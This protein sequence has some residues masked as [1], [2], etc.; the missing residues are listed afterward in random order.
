MNEVIQ[1]LKRQIQAVEVLLAELNEDLSTELK[2]PECNIFEDLDFASAKIEDVLHDR[3]AQDC[4]GSYNC[5]LD[6][7]EQYFMV[8]DKTYKGILEVEYN[9]HDKTYYYID[10]TNFKVEEVV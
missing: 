9:R 8:G 6:K 7:Y 3:A 1:K 10:G 4:E 5:G 2:K